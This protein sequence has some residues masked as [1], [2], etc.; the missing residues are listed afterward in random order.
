MSELSQYF[1]ITLLLIIIALLSERNWF[2]R[3]ENH[4]LKN[5]E[6]N[7]NNMQD[8]MKMM[9]ELINKVNK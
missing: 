1:I 5:K 2:L 6:Q 8:M 7:S 3:R 4:D 9:N